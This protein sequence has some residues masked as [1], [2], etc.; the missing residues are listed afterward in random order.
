MET[1][2]FKA[3]IQVDFA[4][5]FTCISQDE[6][7]RAHWQQAKSSLFTAAVQHSGKMEPIVLCSNNISHGKDTVDAYIET[8]PE[9]TEQVFIWS[10]GPASQF[11]NKY[12]IAKNK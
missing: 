9:E 4:E 12:I 11:K 1:F 3:L 6:I 2:K 8:L 7:E 5:N 10:D